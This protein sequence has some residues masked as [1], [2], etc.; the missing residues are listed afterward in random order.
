MRR[1]ESIEQLLS[2]LEVAWKFERILVKN[3][4]GHLD[5][6][7][8]TGKLD[9][10][11]LDRI[12]F[13]LDQLVKMGKPEELEPL[14][15]APLP[16]NK[17]EIEDGHYRCDRYTKRG[18]AEADAYVLQDASEAKR[19]EVANSAN[20]W[21]QGRDVQQNEAERLTLAVRAVKNGTPREDAAK[22]HT[23][24]MSKLEKHFRIEA[25]D[26]E[27]HRLGIT[28]PLT[29]G[30]KDCLY[31]LLSRTPAFRA[32]A[33]LAADCTIPA[34]DLGDTTRDFLQA[35]DDAAICT[36]EA[37]ERKRRARP[38]G[39]KPRGEKDVLTKIYYAATSLNNVGKQ[40]KKLKVALRVLS[41]SQLTV[42]E[43]ELD[44]GIE[45]LHKIK[46]YL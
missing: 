33:N 7:R 28:K 32:C 26:T 21:V 25:V 13:K 16:K 39:P 20:S 23:V 18:V 11:N 41:P 3:C 38:S 40:T 30:Q 9:Q 44:R 36:L 37:D 45:V 42:L 22:R 15:V 12:D 35:A 2:L 5:D 17:Y 4:R 27:L 34:T 8:L 10:V 1:N 24:S 43:A 31:K 6:I 19:S 29:T 46:T 14:I